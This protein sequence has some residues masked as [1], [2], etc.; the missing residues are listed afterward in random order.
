MKHVVSIIE[1]TL[2]WQPSYNGVVV[3]ASMDVRIHPL[4][5]KRVVLIL[6]GVDGSVDGYDSKYVMMA[7]QAL[8]MGYGV[9]RV[10]NAFISSFHW[11]DNLRQAIAYINTNS[12]EH[13]SNSE[14]TISV[15]AHS[16]GA[17][18]TAWEYPNIEKLILINMASKLKS[19]RIALGLDRYEHDAH[20]VY[21]SKDP[22]VDFID[23]L[24]GKYKTTIIEGADHVFS[25]KHLEDFINLVALL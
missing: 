4:A 25:G 2:A 15:I 14:V 8:A 22:S 18:V 21:G 3:D 11:E 12:Q 16:A 19:E 10:S 9:V 24:P 6:P 1:Q 13:F 5:S 23:Q 20:L 7:D 17:S